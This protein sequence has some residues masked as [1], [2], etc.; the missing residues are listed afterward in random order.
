MQQRRVSSNTSSR[1]RYRLTLADDDPW[2]YSLHKILKSSADGNNERNSERSI[3]SA[4][5]AYRKLERPSPMKRA[6]QSQPIALLGYLVSRLGGAYPPAEHPTTGMQEEEYSD[7]QW[8]DRKRRRQNP[9]T[10]QVSV[11]VPNVD[12]K[13]PHYGTQ[14]PLGAIYPS[15]V[16]LPEGYIMYAHVIPANCMPS[17][18]TD[19]THEVAKTILRG[20][21]NTR[22]LLFGG[23]CF[24]PAVHRKV[25]G[26]DPERRP[27]MLRAH[28]LGRFIGNYRRL[29][30]IM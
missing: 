14:P 26:V 15:H 9:D 11:P 7:P 25:E 4:R 13:S 20:L 30:K 6:K 27:G 10:E 28:C 19:K 23:K 5:S 18:G 2:Y 8:P 29:V 21:T 24:S 17:D 3:A 16:P 1:Y 22:R 12:T